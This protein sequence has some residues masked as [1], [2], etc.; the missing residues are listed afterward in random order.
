MNN[1]IFRYVFAQT[2]HIDRYILR[3]H[4]YNSNDNVEKLPLEL[5]KKKNVIFQHLTD[6]L[7]PILRVLQSNL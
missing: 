2:G 7:M 4:I 5:S 3:V 6:M 1:L